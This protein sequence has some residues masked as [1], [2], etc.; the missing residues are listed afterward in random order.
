M[1]AG[2]TYVFSPQILHP[3]TTGSNL[4]LLTF[5]RSRSTT[6][7]RFSFC[8]DSIFQHGRTSTADLL[9]RR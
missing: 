7:R 3:I 8:S 1:A 6:N 2:L 4:L 9:L 5:S